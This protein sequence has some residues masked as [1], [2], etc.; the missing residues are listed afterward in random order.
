MSDSEQGFEVE[1]RFPVLFTRGASD[2]A[3]RAFVDAIRRRKP[4]RCHRG[5]VVIDDHVARAQPACRTDSRLL[6]RAPD[7][8]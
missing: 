5:L 2:T 8:P 3:N 1:F 4:D 6:R 7:R